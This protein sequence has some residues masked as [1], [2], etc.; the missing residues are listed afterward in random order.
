MMSDGA[1]A[2]QALVKVCF[3]IGMVM[4]RTSIADTTSKADI[5]SVVTGTNV[6]WMV[7]VCCYI[8]VG[9]ATVERCEFDIG[10]K[11]K[12]APESRI[13]LVAGADSVPVNESINLQF[14]TRFLVRQRGSRL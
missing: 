6:S 12:I 7:R 9:E 10:A 13:F 5:A 4:G 14:D 2:A 3:G 11:R 8:N 1:R